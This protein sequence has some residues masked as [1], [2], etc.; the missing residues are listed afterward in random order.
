MKNLKKVLLALVVVAM[1]VSSIVT[2]AIANESEPE[3]TGSV[4]EAQKLYDAVLA[5]E[6]KDD[7]AKKSTALVAF[8]AYIDAN[9]IDPAAEGYAALLE[10]YN[11]LTYEVAN[12]LYGVYLGAKST[13]SLK[14]VF[15]HVA[16][17]PSLDET[18][19][20]EEVEY[21]DFV[22]AVNFASVEYADELVDALFATVTSGGASYYEYLAGNLADMSLNAYATKSILGEAL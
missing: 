4:E 22:K 10:A 11:K 19:A 12:G 7:L 14:A 17:A 18:V 8:Y 16:A 15:T 13:E 9:P 6:I 21:A 2:I 3:Y 1:L 5:E 20:I